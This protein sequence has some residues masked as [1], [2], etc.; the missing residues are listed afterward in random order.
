MIIHTKG[1]KIAVTKNKHMRITVG[2][3]TTDVWEQY[4]ISDLP[5]EK[6]N[7]IYKSPSKGKKYAVKERQIK[8][9]KLIQ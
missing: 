2:D 8:A 5:E 1:D 3:S 6:Q 7:K 9:K 4:D